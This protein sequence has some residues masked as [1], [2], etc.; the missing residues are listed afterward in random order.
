MLVQVLGPG[1]AKCE[2][3]K[4]LVT[5]VVHE[6]KIAATVEHVSDFK[7]IMALGVMSTPAVLVNGASKCTG[8]VPEADEVLAWLREACAGG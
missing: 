4:A 6:H 5:R 8:R 7:E 2:E 3:A 1:C